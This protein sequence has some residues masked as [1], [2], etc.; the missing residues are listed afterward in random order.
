MNKNKHVTRLVFLSMM[1]ALGVVISPI[2]RVEGMCPMAHLINVTCAVMLGPWY[3]LACAFT[4]G[5]IR[6]VCMGIPPLALTGAVFG[7]FL[8]GMLYRLSRGKLVWAFLGEVIGT[9]II[10][11]IL[12]YPVMTWIWGK[13][14]LTCFFYVPSFIAG[15][16][17][18]GS[19]AFLLLK[20]LQKTKMLSVFQ[21]ALGS[22]AYEGGNTV[23]NDA[24]G[25]AFLGLIAALAVSVAVK[26]LVKAPGILAS[27]L[28]YLVLAAFVAAAGIYWI[29]KQKKTG[30]YS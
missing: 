12:S 23:A 19:L 2:L 22:R 6:M 30:E 15:T 21:E 11:A 10:G 3:A 28:K 24:I 8:S 18:G 16:L 25:I 9:G 7:A 14:G 1:V 5:I 26:Q 13:T 27:N 29:K 17:I 4:I 20:H